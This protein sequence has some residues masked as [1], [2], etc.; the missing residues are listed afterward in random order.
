M[1]LSLLRMQQR[2]LSRGWLAWV[3]QCHNRQAWAQVSDAHRQESYERRPWHGPAV[4]VGSAF[5]GYV[6]RSKPPRRFAV[7]AQ[8]RLT[9]DELMGVEPAISIKRMPYGW[10]QRPHSAPRS[11][12]KAA[13]RVHPAGLPSQ[14]PGPTSRGNARSNASGSGA[15]PHVSAAGQR[16]HHRGR[17]VAYSTRR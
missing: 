8:Y 13:V 7:S 1:R 5:A 17:S 16:S 4:Y 9:S 15:R 14:W 2:Q 11:H 12:P 3:A 10:T 6:E